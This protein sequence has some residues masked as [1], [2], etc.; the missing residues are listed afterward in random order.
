MGQKEPIVYAQWYV[1]HLGWSILPLHWVDKGRCTCMRSD[2]G[3]SAGKHPL[4]EWKRFQDEPMSLEQVEEVWTAQP[5]AN[6]GLCTGARSGVVVLDIDPRHGGDIGLETLEAEYSKLPHTIESQTG[7]GGRHLIFK[8]PGVP[9]K[10]KVNLAPGVDVR[11]DGGI[12]VLPYSI[13]ASGKHYEWE[14]SSTPAQVKPADMP[15]WLLKLLATPQ[16]QA[17]GGTKEETDWAKVLLQGA[18]DGERNNT[19]TRLAGRL[20]RKGLSAPEVAAI[21]IIWNQRNKPPLPDDE[22]LRTVESI[23]KAEA[24]RRQRMMTK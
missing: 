19:A 5:R 2:C 15:A 21:C 9:I 16:A 18:L 8:H 1:K 22:V 11:G 14:L 12:I 10:N 24:T 7:G 23:A 13:H 17:P 4:N 20:C 6:I 3:G